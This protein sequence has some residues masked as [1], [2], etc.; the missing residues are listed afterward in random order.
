VNKCRNSNEQKWGKVKRE[1]TPSFF[2]FLPPNQTKEGAVFSLF[3]DKSA[4]PKALW[5][6]ASFRLFV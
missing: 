4:V 5:F 6:A 2:F 3:M 1:K